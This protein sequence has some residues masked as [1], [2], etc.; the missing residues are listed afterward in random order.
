YQVDYVLGGFGWKQRFVTQLGNSK[1]ILPIQW[2]L[3]TEGWVAYHASDWYDGTGE[4]KMIALSQ[5]WDRR[6]AGCHATGVEVEFN[7]T[8]DEWTAT[9]VELG[10]GCEGCHGPGSLH[11]SPPSGED[12]K[13]FIWNPTDSTVCGNCHV[14]GDSVDLVGG[15]A[16]GYPMKDGHAIR[17]GDLLADYY[18][19]NAGFHGD[20]E[21]SKKHHQ[22][23][24]DYIGHTHSTSLSTIQENDHGGDSCLQCHST[25]YILADEDDKPTVETAVNDIECGACHVSHG[26]DIDHDLRLPQ[27]QICTQ[28]H[29]GGDP[30]PGASVHHPQEELV[31]GEL[32]NLPEVPGEPWMDG[33]VTC[34][35]CHMPLT[36][37]SA[38]E[39][40]IASHTFYF[41]SP[42]KSIEFDMPNSCTADCHQEGTPG[43][44]LTDEEALEDIEEG[45]A[46][47]TALL[48]DAAAGLEAAK[49]A[50]DAAEALGYSDTDFEA[51]NVT[52]YKAK[53]AHDVVASDGTMVHNPDYS[54]DLL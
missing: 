12:K 46:D 52:Y 39:W 43:P 20:G 49:A 19:M 6:C 37:K 51:A 31:S 45:E 32:T 23:Y 25:D 13:D 44:T 41:I 28:C 47:T 21:T 42:A 27:E 1:Y 3:E 53:L 17:P 7:S 50:L 24:V 9:Y 5:S 54:E 36:A 10:I 33:D 40:D 30:A 35:D 48:T 15:K 16:T 26:S 2:N 22:Q 4:P 11:V 29:N 18:I 14:R 38:V 34:T 8:S